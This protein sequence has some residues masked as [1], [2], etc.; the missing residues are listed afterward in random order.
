[1]PDTAQVYCTAAQLHRLSGLA[2][3][4]LDGIE[5]STDCSNLS[6]ITAHMV[7]VDDPMRLRFFVIE[8]DGSVKEES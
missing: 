3:D 6:H 5:F 4:A 8:A 7:D 1:M 2:C